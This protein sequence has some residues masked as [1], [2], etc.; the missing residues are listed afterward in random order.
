MNTYFI[1]HPEMVLGE[2]IFDNGRFGNDTTTACKGDGNLE[3]QLKEAISRLQG[4]YQEA[5]SE[6]ME[7]EKGIVQS[8]PAD[9][10]I[11]NFSYTLVNGGLYFWKKRRTN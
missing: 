7:E 9:P 5:T 8:L 2:M 1:E 10:S 11:R 3:E 4:N 6:Y